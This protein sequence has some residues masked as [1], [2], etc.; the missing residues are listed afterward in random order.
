MDNRDIRDQSNAR[1]PTEYLLGPDVV[2]RSAISIYEPT[3]TSF[4][5]ADVRAMISNSDLYSTRN[6]LQR[7]LNVS[8]GGSHHE[9]LS[10]L[11]FH[12]DS[13]QSAAVF[14]I[15]TNFGVRD[16]CIWV[17]GFC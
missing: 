3:D 14:P 16:P 17:S 4:A 11:S 12:L 5:L 13:Q 1:T 2:P 8:A 15:R 6:I 7:I 10:E 9:K